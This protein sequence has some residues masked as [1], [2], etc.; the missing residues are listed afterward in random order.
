MY[1]TDNWI[2]IQ[3]LRIENFKL[4]DQLSGNKTPYS[5]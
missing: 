2:N 3:A 4:S 1:H 5:T